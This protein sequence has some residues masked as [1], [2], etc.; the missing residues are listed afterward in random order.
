V[1]MGSGELHCPGW[2]WD[3]RGFTSFPFICL[4]GSLANLH[5]VLI[6]ISLACLYNM[7]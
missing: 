4:F 3:I 1:V 7:V 6:L 2:A 5:K